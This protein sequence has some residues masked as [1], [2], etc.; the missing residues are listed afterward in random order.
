MRLGKSQGKVVLAVVDHWVNYPKRFDSLSASSLPDGVVVTD[1]FAFAQATLEL[2][3][4][5]PLLWPNRLA[6]ELVNAAQ[7]HREREHSHSLPVILILGEAT[8]GDVRDAEHQPEG[9]LLNS[10]PH[11]L[12]KLG[13]RLNDCRIELRLHP[14]EADNKYEGVLQGLDFPLTVNS[15]AER[16]IT[17]AIAQ[18]DLVL[19]LTS[20]ALF[21]A[22]SV[23]KLTW[24]LAECM[25]LRTPFPPSTVPQLRIDA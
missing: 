11:T 1:S 17:E 15:P 24:S 19:G 22:W 18:A 8:R 3:W 13:Y 7:K 25:G 4:A 2:P 12:G 9:R 14:N 6:A 5:T 16:D 23:G 10:L 21:L 20:Y